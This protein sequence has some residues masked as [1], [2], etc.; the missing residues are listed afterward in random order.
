[1]GK[2]SG[3]GKIPL[4]NLQN[5]VDSMARWETIMK[6]A[7]TVVTIPKKV[8]EQTRKSPQFKNDQ[9]LELY[10]NDMRID[11][12]LIR[13]ILA[14]PR[15]S[16]I[17]DLHKVIY[18]SMARFDY[19]SQE[20]KWSESTHDFILHAIFL[21]KEL[22]AENSLQI[23]LDILR[24]D[25]EYIDYWFSDFLTE[26]IWESIYTLGYNRM[27]ELSSFLKEPN[28]YCYCRTEIS[29][30]VAQIALHHP[31]RRKDVIKWFGEMLTFFLDNKEDNNIIESE[32]IGLMVSDILDIKGSELIPEITEIY[33]NKL[34]SIGVAG[35]LEA[36][37][38]ELTNPT[39]FYDNKRDLMDIFSKYEDIVNTWAGYTE[40]EPIVVND[41]KSDDIFTDN[42]VAEFSRKPG[43]NDPCPCG[44]G[45][46]YK[47]CCLKNK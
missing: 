44:S 13:E 43:R 8:V 38:D 4:I 1:M 7:R 45:K 25:E 18:D 33:Q 9:I 26:G 32:M 2:K 3:M 12:T 29:V 46:K 5:L 34:S 15:E 6:D 31:E 37:I 41:K 19:F 21:L 20:T 11:H 27:D 24:Q 35:D 22:K 10:R 16:L 39:L 17:E 36:I 30:A 40:E 23:L 14:L 42:P 47:K 28:R